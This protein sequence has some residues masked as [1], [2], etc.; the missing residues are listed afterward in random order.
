[1]NIEKLKSWREELRE[2]LI[3]TKSLIVVRQKAFRNLEHKHY[4]LVDAFKIVDRQIAD[5]EKTVQILPAMIKDRRKART[6]VITKQNIMNKFNKL[7]KDD[8]KNFISAL[9]N[10]S[11]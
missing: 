5:I 7:S 10:F 1:M 6:E 4:C 11:K 9:E 3:I 8:R 2:Q